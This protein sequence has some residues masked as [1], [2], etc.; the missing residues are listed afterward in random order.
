MAVTSACVSDLKMISGD[1]LRWFEPGDDVKYGFCSR[2]GGNMFFRSPGWPDR[3]F[4]CAG[5]I[6]PP[7]GLQ[8]VAIT[9]ASTASD[10]VELDTAKTLWPTDWPTDHDI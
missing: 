10:Y 9:Y 6:D 8:S 2:C 4:I 1:A 5:T 3:T 7:T